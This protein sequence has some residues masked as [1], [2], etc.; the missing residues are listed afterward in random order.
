MQV[1]QPRLELSSIVLFEIGIPHIPQ[2]CLWPQRPDECSFH[3][4]NVVDGHENLFDVKV[5]VFFSKSVF[6]LA[7]N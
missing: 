7:F 6:L 3:E 2:C 1:A 4:V 5:M